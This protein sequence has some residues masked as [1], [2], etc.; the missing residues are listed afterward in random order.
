MAY[1]MMTNCGRCQRPFTCNPHLVPVERKDWWTKAGVF[2]KTT[3]WELCQPC[4]EQFRRELLAK[5]EKPPE[6]HPRA[7]EAEPEATDRDK[8]GDLDEP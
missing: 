1:F 3:R 5:G 2:V 4:A 7:Y 8:P 6:I